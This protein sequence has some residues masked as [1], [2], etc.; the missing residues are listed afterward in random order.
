MTITKI[1]TDNTVSASVQ[2]TE[3]CKF[4]SGPCRNLDQGVLI[5]NTITTICH[6]TQG[7]SSL[8]LWYSSDQRLSCPSLQM[9]TSDPYIIDICNLKIFSST[10]G[11]MYSTDRSGDLNDIASTTSMIAL[12]TRVEVQ[13]KKPEIRPFLGTEE[14]DDLDQRSS[15]TTT[16][17]KPVF[18]PI[19]IMQFTS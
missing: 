9:S 5:F 8:C 13:R 7:D 11:L 18:N 16:E 14:A 2:L 6:L 12:A 1:K 4:E 10:Q 19:S 15:S 3:N 17:E